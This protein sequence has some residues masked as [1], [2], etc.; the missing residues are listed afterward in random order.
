MDFVNAMFQS[1]KNLE[2]V[3]L[4]KLK[5]NLN[6]TLRFCQEN[7]QT[8]KILNLGGV[9]GLDL[10]LISLIVTKC[11]SL[12]ELSFSQR[13]KKAGLSMLSEESLKF[14][15]ENLTQTILKLNLENQ[16]Y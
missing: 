1:C 11:K 15:T 12:T 2:N 13:T 8:L 3:S 16:V 6:I 7:G 9:V 4:T 14:L 10:E 5:L